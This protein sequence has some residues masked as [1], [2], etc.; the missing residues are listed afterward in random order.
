MAQENHDWG[1]DRIVGR[2]PIWG[3]RSAI[4]RSVMSCAARCEIA[5]ICCTTA[6]QVHPVIPSDH[7]VGS[8]RTA[9]AACPQPEPETS[10]RSLADRSTG[11]MGCKEGHRPILCLRYKLSHRQQGWGSSLMP[12]ARALIVPRDCHHRN[13]D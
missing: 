1:Y 13:H 6:K 5:A 11:G 2:W 9:R 3:I 10:E 12:R 8:S 7:C 4:R